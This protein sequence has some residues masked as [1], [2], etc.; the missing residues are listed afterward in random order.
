MKNK[1][2]QQLSFN[3]CC[4]FLDV[5]SLKLYAPSQNQYCKSPSELMVVG[6][7]LYSLAGFINVS[8]QP[9]ASSNLQILLPQLPEY[10]NYMCALPV[11]LQFK[12]RQPLPLFLCCWRWNPGPHCMP[13]FLRHLAFTL[14]VCFTCLV[15]GYLLTAWHEV[16]PGGRS[17]LL[18]IW[19]AHFLGEFLSISFF[20][21]SLG[22]HGPHYC[23][24]G[25]WKLNEPDEGK[26]PVD[27]KRLLIQ[28]IDLRVIFRFLIQ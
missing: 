20:V 10:W 7:S 24:P 18:V 5:Y 17:S 8:V 22:P 6:H 2:C 4:R 23:L 25:S 13:G 28:L 9:R 27:L 14:E 19:L 12:L 15:T 1:I 11:V 21:F 16:F 26:R 3:L